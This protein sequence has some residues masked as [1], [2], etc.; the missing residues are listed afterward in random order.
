MPYTIDVTTYRKDTH[1]PVGVG[2]SMRPGSV[3][4]TTIVIHTTSAT[5]QNTTFGAEA[6]FL[7][8]SREVSAHYLNGKSS[9]IVQFLHPDQI[10]RASCRERV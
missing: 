1:L 3:K 6:R 4:P 2:W 8:N 5:A 9:Q 7:Y 10:G